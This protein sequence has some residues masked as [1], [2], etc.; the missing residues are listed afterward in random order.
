MLSKYIEVSWSS[1]MYV[2]WIGKL[3]LGTASSN[4]CFDGSHAK[5]FCPNI[6]C[7]MLY[8]VFTYKTK[9]FG[10]KSTLN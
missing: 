10:N 6:K 1:P 4:I 9:M 5:M 2:L 3:K 7:S 8:S